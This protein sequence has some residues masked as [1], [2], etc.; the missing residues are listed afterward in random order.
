MTN[1]KKVCSVARHI[2]TPNMAIMQ[3]RP[4]DHRVHSHSHL[5][6]TPNPSTLQGYFAHEKTHPPRT[7][8]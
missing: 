2:A 7:L 1:R 4:S 3:H 8:P 5:A 6:V